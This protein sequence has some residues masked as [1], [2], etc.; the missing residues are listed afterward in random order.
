MR[1][2][3]IALMLGS[4]ALATSLLAAP[5][6]AADYPVLRGSQIEDAPPA[7]SQ[8]TWE[9]FYVGGFAGQAQSRF[10]RDQSVDRLIDYAMLNTTIASSINVYDLTR[11]MPRRDSGSIFGGYVGYNWAFGDVV[12]GLEADYSRIDQ[13]A[14]ASRLE[15]RRVGNEFLTVGLNQSA[16]INDYASLRARFGYAYGRLMPYFTIGAA[17]GRFD[18]NVSVYSDWGPTDVNGVALGSYVGWPRMV[19][20]PKKDV[21]GFGGV[22]GGGIEAALTDNI[23]VR[24]EYLY[25]RFH[26]VEGVTTS[27]NQ[28]RVGAA[29]KF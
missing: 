14:A 19:G 25:T 24:A 5:T 8:F 4:T 22:I 29:L 9:G 11:T 21:W 15:S 16:R 17:V 10:E 6:L 27:L 23:L 12:M 20:G 3:S 26:D 1:I 2:R 13:E 28:A 18:T 7:P